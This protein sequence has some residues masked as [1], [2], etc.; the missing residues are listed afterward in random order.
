M[1]RLLPLFFRWGEQLVC[2]SSC[3]ANIS[4]PGAP[5]AFVAFT[6][7][8]LPASVYSSFVKHTKEDRHTIEKHFC[9]CLACICVLT[10]GK[11][12]CKPYPIPPGLVF[13][14]FNLRQQASYARTGQSQATVELAT[15]Y[16]SSC[17]MHLYIQ[18]SWKRL[19]TR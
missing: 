5:A 9:S 10:P 16:H 19:A 12:G 2:Y 13:H 7:S 11:Q 3:C 14:F 1:R 18:T 17:F 15:V 8:Y 4:C 6:F